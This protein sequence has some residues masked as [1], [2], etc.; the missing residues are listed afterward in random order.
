MEEPAPVEGQGQLP[1][2][3]QGS[4]R[5]AVAAALALDGESTLGRRKKKKKES[6]PESIIIYRSENEKLGEEPEEPEGRDPR[7][8]EEGDDFLDYP[9]DDGM[10]NMPLDSCYVTLTGT[11]T[12][13]KKKGQVVDIHVTL[14]EKELQELTKPPEATRETTP[15]GRKACQM[16]ADRGPHVLLWTLACLPV[17]FILSFVVS[18]YY[19]TITWYNIFLVYNEERTFWHKIACCP[20]LILFYPV[21]IMA[22]AAS[23]GLYAAVVQLSWSWGAWWQAA[24][25]MEKGFCGWLCSKLGLE[26]CSPYSIVELLESDNISGNLSNKDPTQEVETSTV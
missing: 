22:M 1:S 23:L 19:G 11:I 13:G 14:T 8:E 3:H 12:R 18:F 25:D 24:R 5:K 17:V 4:L 20:C 9:A 21:L 6:R 7:K 26:D 15:E 10:W 2:P 16:G